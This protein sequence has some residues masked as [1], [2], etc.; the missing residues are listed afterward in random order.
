MEMDMD[1]LT[2]ML[3][4]KLDDSAFREALRIVLRE[5]HTEDPEILTRQALSSQAFS[6]SI[7]SHALM[8]HVTDHEGYDCV[9]EGVEQ[10]V[11]AYEK[12]LKSACGF[13]A[14]LEDLKDPFEELTNNEQVAKEIID[15]LEDS[16]A[17]P[18]WDDRGEEDAKCPVCDAV[19]PGA[20]DCGCYNDIHGGRD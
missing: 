19:S 12:E 8:W 11:V 6:I 14:D 13:L 5:F 18:P 16:D 10:R 17:D 4:D 2:K 15:S 9:R 1:R 7:M 20:M 3:T